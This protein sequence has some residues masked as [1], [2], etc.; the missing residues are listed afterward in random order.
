MLANLR[1]AAPVFALATLASTTAF[2]QATDPCGGIQFEAIGECH[3]EFD[4]GCE[5]KCEPL[6]FTAACDGRCDLDVTSECSGTCGA[7]CVAACDAD[8]GRFDCR[9]SCTADC[10]ADAQARCGTDS[11]CVSYFQAECSSSCE[12]ECDVVPPSADC[13]AQ[14]QGCCSG[15]CTVDANFDCQLDCTADLQG[16]CEVDCREPTGALFCDGKYLPV[17]D[18]PACIDYLLTNYEISVD[19][20]A[21]ASGQ[22]NLACSVTEPGALTDGS[23]IYGGLLGLGL[24]F[25]RSRRRR[26]AS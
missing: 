2:A 21:S 7:E 18:L 13:E 8:P 5:A 19:F 20:Q 16:G 4:G 17:V 15:S 1:L 14:C 26:R 24:V 23:A 12:A 11:E 6:A 25:A 3:F 9:A 22:A 10:Q